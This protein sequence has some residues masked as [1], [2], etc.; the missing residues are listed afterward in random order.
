[1]TPV[2]VNHIMALS[3]DQ[4]DGL[5]HWTVPAYSSQLVPFNVLLLM[6]FQMLFVVIA[7]SRPP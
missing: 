5:D 4:I 3:N 2:C 7:Q 1:M 6:T